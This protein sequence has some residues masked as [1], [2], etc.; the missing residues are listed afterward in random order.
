MRDISAASRFFLAAPCSISAILFPVRKSFSGL[1]IIILA[2]VC[3]L[4]VPTPFP[5]GVQAQPSAQQETPLP[6]TVPQ[7]PAAIA[8]VVV[9][10]PG[11]GGTDSGA[12]GESG[13]I[14]KDA[15]LEFARSVRGELERQGYRVVMTRND[16]SNPSYDDRAAIANAYRDAVFVSFHISSTGTVGTARAYYYEFWTPIP[17]ADRPAPAA[18]NNSAAAPPPAATLAPGMTVWE[19][20]QRPHAEAS[21][22]FADAVQAELAQRFPNSP[23]KSIGAE[24]RGLRSI[25]AP[26]VAVEISCVSV[27]DPNSLMA[28]AAPLATSIAHSVFAFHPASPMGPK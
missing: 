13:A 23:G 25:D 11:H 20:A 28:M 16:D 18:T 10:D 7:S 17:V 8:P 26:A 19:E 1:A 4:A 27:S 24:I 6:P 3:I 21:H 22:R 2:T 5:A 12:R 14:E 15:V 9:L